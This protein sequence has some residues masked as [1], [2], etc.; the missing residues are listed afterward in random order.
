MKMKIK[1]FNRPVYGP[2]MT[3]DWFAL[4]TG[5]IVISATISIVPF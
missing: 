5:F 1:L 3:L 4:F 2:E